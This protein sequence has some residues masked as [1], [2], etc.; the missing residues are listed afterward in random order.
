MTNEEFNEESATLE[1]DVIVDDV[2]DTEKVEEAPK[3]SSFRKIE[4]DKEENSFNKN[5]IDSPKPKPN[6][7]PSS[8]V[9][10]SGTFVSPGADR[11]SDKEKKSELSED[12]V[13]LKSTKNVHWQGVG[14]LYRGYNIVKKDAAEKWL[15]R[16]HVTLATPEEIARE[17]NV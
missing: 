5:L 2:V 17:F 1:N 7:A 6:K 12:K 11:V 16:E 15:K 4:S 10:D 13:A 3:P 9:S 8:N 14:R